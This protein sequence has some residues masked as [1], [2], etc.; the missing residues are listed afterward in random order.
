MIALER[1]IVSIFEAVVD[2]VLPPH[3]DVRLARALSADDLAS[4]YGPRAAGATWA[5][6]LFPYRDPKVQALIRAV[7]YRGE[8]R[9]LVPAAEILGSWIAE[10]IAEKRLFAGWREPIVVPIPSSPARL[11]A[12]G[13]NQTERIART[14]L[15]SIGDSIGYAPHALSRD[16]RPSQVGIERSERNQN[17]RNAFHVPDASMIKGRFVIVIDDVIE[18]GSTVA[19]A[20]RALR[21]AG[22]KDVI[23]VA[24]AH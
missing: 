4:L 12:R 18:T 20:R 9:A 23:A 11:R 2:A 22:A 21:A 7:K 19:D 24:L 8:T 1:L 13:Y 10:T 6:A 16:D 17:V 3:P 5:T 15:D 14:T